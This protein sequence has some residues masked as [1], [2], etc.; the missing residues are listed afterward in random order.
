MFTEELAC[1]IGIAYS[2]YKALCDADGKEAISVEDF[3]LLCR[4]NIEE[5]RDISG[6]NIND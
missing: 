4:K 5:V 2:I 1:Q 6:L 3:R